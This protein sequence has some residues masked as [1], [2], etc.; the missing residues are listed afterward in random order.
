M[1]VLTLLVPRLALCLDLALVHT[2]PVSLSLL[3]AV[4]LSHPLLFVVICAARPSPKPLGSE[5]MK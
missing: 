1:P 2:L 4:C 3:I 5:D